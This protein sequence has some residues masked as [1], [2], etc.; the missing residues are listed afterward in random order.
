MILEVEFSE[1][2][3]QGAGWVVVSLLGGGFSYSVIRMGYLL[4]KLDPRGKSMAIPILVIIGFLAFP[5]TTLVSI[6]L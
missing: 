6:Y 3:K 1:L 5:I 2:I 4:R